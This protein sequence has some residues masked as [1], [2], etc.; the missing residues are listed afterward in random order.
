MID[1]VINSL[2]PAARDQFIRK[3]TKSVSRKDPF[4][5]RTTP[6]YP[7]IVDGQKPLTMEEFIEVMRAN[8]SVVVLG[9]NAR[10][11]ASW[12]SGMQFRI[13]ANLIATN[14]IYLYIPLSERTQPKILT[15]ADTTRKEP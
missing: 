2:T 10:T 11:S 6:K 15:N 14:N 5:I 8:K 9:W 3:L 13:V 7:L 1:N 4:R 12:L